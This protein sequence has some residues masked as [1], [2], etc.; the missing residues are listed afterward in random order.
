M[1]IEEMKTIVVIGAGVMGQ[2]IAMNTA[3]KGR[4]SG[5]QVILCDSFPAA[6]EKAQAW[7]DKYL[8]GRIAKGRLSVSDDGKTWRPIETF[9]LGNLINDPSPRAVRF[10]APSE[11]RYV[12]LES[13]EI[14]GGSRVAAIGEIDFY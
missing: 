9:E 2:Q 10:K 7:A 12:K 14:A 3:I 13:M 4:P 11:G 5:Y 6:V 1:K 8:A